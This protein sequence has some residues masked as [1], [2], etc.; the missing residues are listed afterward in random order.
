MDDNEKNKLM[1]IGIR[2]IVSLLC[3]LGILFVTMLNKN[4]VYEVVLLRSMPVKFLYLTV[5]DI[6]ILSSILL[7]NHKTIE[8]DFK[9]ILKNHK[10]GV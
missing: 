7:V 6:L 4:A 5:V 1:K 9:D 8:H 10:K 3:S 2:L